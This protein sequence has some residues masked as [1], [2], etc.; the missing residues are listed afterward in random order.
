MFLPELV[1]S[2]DCTVT[3]TYSTGETASHTYN[4]GSWF[5]HAGHLITHAVNVFNTTGNGGGAV[6]HAIG[7]TLLATTPQHADN[8]KLELDHGNGATP[9]MD[10]TISTAEVRAATGLN[11]GTGITLPHTNAVMGEVFESMVP[12]QTHTLGVEAWSGSSGVASDGT[13]YSTRGET[14]RTV[15]LAVFIDTR[16]DYSEWDAWEHLW[17]EFWA[18]GRHVTVWTRPASQLLR[19][20]SVAHSMHVLGVLDDPEVTMTRLQREKGDAFNVSGPFKFAERMPIPRT[21][22][23]RQPYV[24]T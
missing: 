5:A 12:L 15:S 3:I 20:T 13:T 16:T 19:N 18:Q 11:S 1:L 9:T 8:L 23:P 4:A 2:E 14:L 10:L 7:V 22:G 6:T 21:E 24:L 17:E